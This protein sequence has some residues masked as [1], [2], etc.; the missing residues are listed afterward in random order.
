MTVQWRVA[1]T[2]QNGSF[3]LYRGSIVNALELVAEVPARSG[4]DIYRFVDNGLAGGAFFYQLRYRSATGREA[5]LA[6]AFCREAEAVPAATGVSVRFEPADTRV[7]SSLDDFTLVGSAPG[8][9]RPRQL[10][11]TLRPPVPP[12]EAPAPASRGL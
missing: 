11:W 1:S 4:I 5:V 8:D 2:S 10:P 12:P 3:R 9:I 6:T 7:P